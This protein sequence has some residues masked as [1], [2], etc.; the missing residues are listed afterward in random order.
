[1]ELRMQNEALESELHKLLPGNSQG[2]AGM[3]AASSS[4]SSSPLKTLAIH[5]HMRHPP[6][7]SAAPEHDHGMFGSDLYDNH[8]A[9]RSPGC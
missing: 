7:H 1:M 2:S 3:N 4:S 6:E 9:P 8:C 5:Q